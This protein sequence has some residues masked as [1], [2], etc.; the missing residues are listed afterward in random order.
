MPTGQAGNHKKWSYLVKKKKNNE[1]SAFVKIGDQTWHAIKFPRPI[2]FFRTSA[3]PIIQKND[4]VTLK[5]KSERT[6]S[7]KSFSKFP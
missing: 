1:K 3:T 2:K 7:I 4:L 6:E 5:V